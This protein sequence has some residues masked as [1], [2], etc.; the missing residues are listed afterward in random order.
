MTEPY[1][2]IDKNVTF[3]KMELC[4]C[5]YLQMS[6]PRGTQEGT[7][8]VKYSDSIFLLIHDQQCLE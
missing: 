1:S 3:K 8:R 5:E 4:F 6:K 2:D 7:L